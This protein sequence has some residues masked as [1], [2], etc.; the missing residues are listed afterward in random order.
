M[1]T[2]GIDLGTTYS[3][4]S[5]VGDD[6]MPVVVRNGRGEE[7]T[8]SVVY[9]E[10]A[11]NVV[12]GDEA[13]DAAKSDAER[14]VAL[15]KRHMGSR[16]PVEL[17]FDGITYTPESVSA[18][19]V[20]DLARSAVAA[21]G[22][23]VDDVVITV[24]A[25]FGISERKATADA[26]EI[27]GLNVVSVVPEPV[28]A[29]LHY[30]ALGNGAAAADRTILVYDLGGGTFDTTVIRL[31]G[32]DVTVVCTD[33]DHQLGG[34]DWDERIVSH[35]RD[36]FVAEHPGAGA[37][38]SEA[39]LQSLGLIAED[40]K[41]ALSVRM[42]KRQPIQFEGLRALVEMTRSTFEEL[43][44]DLLDRTV[45]ITRRTLRTAQELGCRPPDTVLLVGG[46]T[47]MPAVA[48]AL[49]QHFGFEP[50]LH[51]PQLAVAKGA[52][53]F[54]LQETVRV[55]LADTG[56]DSA[57]RK[58]A[59][60]LGVSS[61]LIRTASAKKVTIVVPRAFGTGIVARGTEPEEGKIE[62]RHLLFAN[63][64]L[65][66]KPVTERFVTAFK[67]QT[68]IT[69]DIWEQAGT[70]VSHL[71]EDN[72]RIGDGEISRLPPLPKGSPIDITFAMNETGVLKV[73]A[74]E[75]VTGQ[76][77]HIEVQIGG[78]D[79]KRV[80]QAREAITRLS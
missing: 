78:L 10:S 79:A 25:Y 28:A 69:I 46:S 72:L 27:A 21:T 54:A 32:D 56:D 61:D 33:G 68:S 71:P 65:P 16:D 51:D 36:C 52:A 8:P 43:T 40:L 2:F 35:L 37:G 31:S 20:R 48:Q 67:D 57:I 63:T 19:I 53:M 23:P 6:G 13:K 11:H 17:E 55:R 41:K 5:Y 1:A 4:I 39:F 60:D 42:T 50:Q 14:V 22:G 64:P 73:D 26:G 3:C 34:A 70:D 59:G 80:R 12:V 75:L 45:E 7:L 29:A 38:A 58:I 77:V 9:F 30:G 24:P 44:A 47:L 49:R 18:F 76:K 74:I 62:V 15:I 66:S